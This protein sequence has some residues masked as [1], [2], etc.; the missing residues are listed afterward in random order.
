MDTEEIIEDTDTAITVAEV[1]AL[2]GGTYLTVKYG[3]KL[4]RKMKE[5]ADEKR[6]LGVINDLLANHATE[7]DIIE[8][9]KDIYP[10]ATTA[11]VA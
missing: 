8:A 6:A 9:L 7:V 4:I 2:I 5:R 11:E 10:D 3:R 1:A